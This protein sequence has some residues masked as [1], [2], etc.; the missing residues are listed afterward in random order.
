MLACK[1]PVLARMLACKQP[2]LA[3]CCSGRSDVEN[4]TAFSARGILEIY[5]F[6]RCP[7]TSFDLTKNSSQLVARF[8]ML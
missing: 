7:T 4:T 1:Q 6:V 8:R 3:I 5:C 2:T